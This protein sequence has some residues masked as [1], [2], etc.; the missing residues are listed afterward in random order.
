MKKKKILTLI[1]ILIVGSVLSQNKKDLNET[2]NRLRQDSTDLEHTIED[3]NLMID[4]LNKEILNFKKLY[5]ELYK[6]NEVQLMEYQKIEVLLKEKESANLD[7]NESIEKLQNSLDSVKTYGH[8]TRFVKAFYN[9]LELS[10]DEN[11]RQY[12]FGDVKFNLDN[13]SALIDKNANYSQ[14]RVDNLSDENYHDRYYVEL[15]SIDE[16]K[17]ANNKIIVSTKVLY[18]ASEMGSFYNEEELTLQ[19]QKGLLKLTSWL[20]VDLFKMEPSE[21]EHMENFTKDDFYEWLGSFNKN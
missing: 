20:D 14:K 17:I 19:E 12:E 21:Y 13:F 6:K 18:S 15:L 5:D 16:I 10:E 1:L 3:N 7:L 8:I 9:S 11:K 4:S 2:I